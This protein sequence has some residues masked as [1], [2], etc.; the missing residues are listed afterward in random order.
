MTPGKLS[1]TKAPALKPRRRRIKEAQAVEVEPDAWERFE[2]AVG[3][4]APPK[5]PAPKAKAES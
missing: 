4:L 2:K 3:Q 1:D 5:K